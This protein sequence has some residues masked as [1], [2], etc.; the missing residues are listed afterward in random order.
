M[1]SWRAYGTRRA[2]SSPGGSGALNRAG[3]GT[4]AKSNFSSDDVKINGFTGIR[5]FVCS[6]H[7][8]FVTN[9]LFYKK[10]STE[11]FSTSRHIT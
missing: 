11:K 10:Q 6:F 8:A 5:N 3:L 1:F 7:V 4:Q 9:T 2:S